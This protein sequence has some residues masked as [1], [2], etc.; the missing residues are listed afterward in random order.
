LRLALSRAAR[1]A[2]PEPA[3]L[4][5]LLRI[6]L[7]LVVLLLPESDMAR[8]VAARPPELHLRPEGLAWL[9]TWVPLGTSFVGA[10]VAAMRASAVLVVLGLWTRPALGV[11]AATM[12]IVFGAA[13]LTGTVTHDMH[14]FWIALIMTPSRA[15]EALS[16]DAW[17]RGR[18]LAGP[19]P[20]ASSGTVA[21]FVRVWMG[22][23]YGFPGLHK[24][25][26]GGGIGFGWATSDNLRNQMWFK[27]FEAGAVPWLRIDRSLA[28]MHAGAGAVLAFELAMPLLVLF[29]RTRWIALVGCVVFHVLTGMFLNVLFPSLIACVVIHLSFGRGSRA[30]ALVLPV[31][32]SRSEPKLAALIALGAALTLAIAIQ[33]ARGKTQAFPFACYP[34]F[35]APAPS[36]IV[37]L[38]VD[39]DDRTY[40]LP[41]RR[42]P[43]EWGM[44][45]RLAGLYGDPLDDRALEAFAVAAMGADAS[46][47]SSAKRV[48]F[49]AEAYDVSPEAWASPA[50]SRTTLRAR[51]D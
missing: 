26:A 40:R 35:A 11:L 44:V 33:G 30:R 3:F 24:L 50:R 38:A 10:C 5:A 22:L 15:G 17:A 47:L 18:P 14:L 46:R 19:A 34:T 37:D 32:A 1:I 16:L 45:W 28:L 13:Q 23:I 36:E 12:L 2:P 39:V 29:R 49:V 8:A 9:G 4:L 41:R 27:W 20:D 51:G 43:D 48:R 42:R 31:E 25:L 21:F 6:T 7:G